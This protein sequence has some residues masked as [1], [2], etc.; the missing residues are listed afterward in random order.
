MHIVAICGS[1]RRDSINRKLLHALAKRAPEGVTVTIAEL[2]GIPVYDGDVEAEGFPPAVTALQDQIAAADGVILG[3]P[4]YNGGVPGPLKN[5]I[6]WCSRG[7]M[8]EVFA[9]RPFGL[10]GA[11]PGPSGTRSAQ[12]AWLSTFRVLGVDAWLAGMLFVPHAQRAL[13]DDGTITDERT[14]RYTQRY[15]DGF[16]D[17]IRSRQR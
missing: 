9:G 5:A 3:S 2:H 11:T 7:R 15:I 4:E 10:V 14:E 12:G 1:M 16:V 6:D 8:Q 13:G 17:F